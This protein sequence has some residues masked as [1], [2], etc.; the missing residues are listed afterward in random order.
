MTQEKVYI[1]SKQCGSYQHIEFDYT[2]K[3]N[4]LNSELFIQLGDA[5]VEAENN[6]QVRTI[7]L[8][9]RGTLFSV[10]GDLD[11]F[12][13]NP[14]AKGFAATGF[15]QCMVRMFRCNKPIV[16]AVHGAAV[17]GAATLLLSCDIV[18][19]AE[20]T[21][22]LF[23]F[24]QLGINAELCS[25]YLLPLT[26][27]MR[28][29]SK[30]ILLSEPVDSTEAKEAGLVTDVVPMDQLDQRAQKYISRLTELVPRSLR[31]NKRLLRHGHMAALS[32]VL[33]EESKALEEGFAS[34]EL[35]EAIA[36]FKGKRKAD[37]SRFS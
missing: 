13:D 29:A 27:G 30:W 1:Q 23:P 26:V 10:G 32:D 37:F 4:A 18:V 7:L 22:F 36:A 35:Q 5:I 6:P 2:E 15:Y 3:K 17:G 33:S 34:E 9:G 19:A 16:A 28:Y 14:F 21:T 20:G 8:T 25:S 12:K 11:D 31:T 24:S